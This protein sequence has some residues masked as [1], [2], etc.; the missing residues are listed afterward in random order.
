MCVYVE[1]LIK[2]NR[3]RDDSRG[4]IKRKSHKDVIKHVAHLSAFAKQLRRDR[5]GVEEVGE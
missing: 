2:T 5:D 1:N 3:N 4:D